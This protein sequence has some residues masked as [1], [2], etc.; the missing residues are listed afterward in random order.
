MRSF[1]AIDR[2]GRAGRRPRPAIRAASG[3]LGAGPF[4]GWGLAA[5]F[6]LPALVLMALFKL[7][8]IGAAVVASTGDYNP[9]GL[10]VGTSGLANFHAVLTDDRFA[11]GMWLALLAAVAKVP[12]QIA[13][14]LAAALLLR[15]NS[16]LNSLTRAVIVSPMFLGLPVTTFLFAYLFDFNVGFVNAVLTGLGLPRVGWLNDPQPAQVVILGLS[17]W[18]D[19]GLTMLVF[20]AGLTAIPRDVASAARL[21][22]AGPVALLFT[23]TLPLLARSFQFAVVLTTLASFQLLVPILMLTH[24]GPSGATDIASY[25]IYESAFVYF[26]LG[27]ASAMSLLLMGGLFVVIALQMRWLRVEW[28]YE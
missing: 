16:R 24:G 12:V 21:D 27:R 7:W 10:R 11:W 19:V 26:D 6:L 22:G 14:G 15:A 17:V 2:D 20:L 25:Q 3:R 18:R 13:L 4:S 5:A 9:G 28:S 23:M 8:P 1:A